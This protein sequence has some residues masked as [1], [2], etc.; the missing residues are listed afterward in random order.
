MSYVPAGKVESTKPPVS[1]VL[2]SRDSL[3][4]RWVTLTV[5]SGTAAPEASVTFPT[6]KPKRNWA[7]ATRP[8]NAGNIRARNAIDQARLKMGFRRRRFQHNARFRRYF[9]M[10]YPYLRCKIPRF[11]W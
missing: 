6:N 10:D 3:V 7:S 2:T 5:A 11:E 4:S 1:F 9:D 8:A